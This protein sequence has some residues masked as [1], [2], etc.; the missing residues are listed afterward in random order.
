[1]LPDQAR[2]VASQVTAV[3]LANT[4]HWLLD[5]NPTE[6]TATLERF[7]VGPAR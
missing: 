1:M 5:E 4:G 6:T 7:L 3:I 2:L